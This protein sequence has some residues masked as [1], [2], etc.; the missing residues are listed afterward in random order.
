MPLNHKSKN[1]SCQNIPF[2]RRVVD[3]CR[4]A[5]VLPGLILF[6]HSPKISIWEDSVTEY[7]Q[8]SRPYVSEVRSACSGH[9]PNQDW[10]RG[11]HC[12]SGTCTVIF[13]PDE[14]R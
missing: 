9:G 12:E 2:V 13:K 7:Q 6:L 14:Y 4:R 3:K 8:S 11:R 5:S 10:L 1:S